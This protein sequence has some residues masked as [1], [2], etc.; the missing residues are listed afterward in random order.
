MG[1]DVGSPVD[2]AY[3]APFTFRGHFGEPD[4]RSGMIDM[5]STQMRRGP[6]LALRREGRNSIPIPQHRGSGIAG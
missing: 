4:G 3:E 1:Q 2:D 6:S 5:R